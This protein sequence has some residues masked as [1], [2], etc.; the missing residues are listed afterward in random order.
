MSYYLLPKINHNIEI[1]FNKREYKFPFISESLYSQFI[2]LNMQLDKL[3]KQKNKKIE[4]MD[5]YYFLYKNATDTSNCVSKLRFS[6]SIFYQFIEINTNINL[7]SLLTQDKLSIFIDCDFSLDIQE[8]VKFIYDKP[9]SFILNDFNNTSTYDYIILNKCDEQ[10]IV[11]DYYNKIIF[12]INKLNKSGVLVVRIN[13]IFNK[14]SVDMIY[15]LLNMFEKSYI[16]RPTTT[17]FYRFEKYIICKGYLND[18][19]PVLEPNPKKDDY[20]SFLKNNIPT[21]LLNKLNDINI[22]T[23]QK[24]LENYMSI[25]QLLNSNNDSNKLDIFDKLNLEKCISWCDKYKVPCNKFVEKMNIFL[26]HE[27]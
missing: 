5:S 26:T 2:F 15:I 10:N 3:I 22:I 14:S 9:S 18:Q 1:E 20:T 21:Y 23:G 17:P 6:N 24:M 25:I 4:I 13:D 7:K 19:N 11:K 27:I 8:S 16:F 12:M